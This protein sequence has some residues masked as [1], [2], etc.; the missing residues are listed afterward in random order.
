MV[1]GKYF[2]FVGNGND[3]VFYLFRKK[4]I[5][6]GRFVYFKFIFGTVNYEDV[7]MREICSK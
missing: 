2:I 6:R 1:D 5:C 3:Y 7:P 4:D